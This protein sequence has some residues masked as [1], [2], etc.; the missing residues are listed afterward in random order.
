MDFIYQ[1]KCKLA[2]TKPAV[3]RT[4]LVRSTITFYE[5]H[6]TLQISMG[7]LNYHLFNFQYHDY[8]LELPNVE[9]DEYDTFGKFQKIDPRKIIL[10]EFFI[11][12]KTVINYTYDFGDSWKHEISLQKIIEP[13][14]VSALLPTCIKGK[15]ACP[16]EDCGSIPGYYNLI[17]IMKNPKHREYKDYVEWLGEPFDMEKFDM[18]IVNENLKGL[19]EYSLIGNVTSLTIREDY[20]FKKFK[21]YYAKGYK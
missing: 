12:P 3:F 5:L 7:W 6:H 10:N 2:Y 13:G 19:K 16:P 14:D 8:Y 17:D 11:S 21:I 1:L 15:Y 18:N 9:D 20:C 4:I